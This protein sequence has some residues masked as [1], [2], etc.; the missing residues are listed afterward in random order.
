[1]MRTF[2]YCLVSTVE[3]HSAISANFSPPSPR[4]KGPAALHHAISEGRVEAGDAGDGVHLA[5]DEDF[6]GFQVGDDDAQQIVG[7]AGQQVAVHH[8]VQLA[9]GVLELLH[10]RAAV[11]FE[12][13]ADEGGDG[14]AV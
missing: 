2:F 12:A 10:Q 14:Q 11:A 9:D 13:D 1:M 3:S 7:V 6:I 5:A 4:R 8:F